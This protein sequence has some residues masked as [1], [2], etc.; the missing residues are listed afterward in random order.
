MSHNDKKNGVAF[1][2]I[3]MQESFATNI[4]ILDS[5]ASNHSCRS[6]EGLTDVRD[7]DEPIKIGNGDTMQPK[8]GN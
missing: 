1:T 8:L 4:W 7:I 6:M 2:L 5:G 3:M